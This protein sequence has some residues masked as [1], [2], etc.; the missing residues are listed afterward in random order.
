M[1]EKAISQAKV[2]TVFHSH[3]DDK[4][5]Q[6]DD[7]AIQRPSRLH[8]WLGHTF[9]GHFDPEYLAERD[10]LANAAYYGRWDEVSGI[11]EAAERRYSESWVNTSRLCE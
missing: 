1:H 5:L 10:A 11:L 6:Q 3:V 9:R 7:E 8:V 2:I 4:S